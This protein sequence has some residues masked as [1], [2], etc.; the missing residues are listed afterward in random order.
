MESVVT[1]AGERWDFI[2]NADKEIDNYWI[3]FRGLMDCDERFTSAHQVGI[4]H[5]KGAELDVY[6]EGDP[7]YE[8]SHK[9]GMVCIQYFLQ[10]ILVFFQNNLSH[11]F[12]FASALDKKYTDM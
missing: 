5:Y 11:R 9:E 8:S 7:D 12:C 2:V 10:N 4:L 3:R 1:Y 6:P